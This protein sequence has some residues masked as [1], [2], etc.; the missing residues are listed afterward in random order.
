[1][2]SALPVVL[3]GYL[4]SSE[5]RARDQIWLGLRDRAA[6]IAHTFST[7]Q[8]TDRT[9]TVGRS[10]QVAGFSAE[11]AGTTPRPALPGPAPTPESLGV[12]RLLPTE[13]A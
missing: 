10:A 2:L 3:C 7:E 5:R 1:V 4:E 12:L 13:P 8:M 11:T 9:R 6:A